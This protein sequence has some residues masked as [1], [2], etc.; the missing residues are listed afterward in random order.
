MLYH[1]A[2]P[3]RR[4]LVCDVGNGRDM[5]LMLLNIWWICQRPIVRS[6]PG[7]PAALHG[8]LHICSI[9]TGLPIAALSGCGGQSFTVLHRAVASSRVC[10]QGACSRGCCTRAHKVFALT[11]H[12]KTTR[13]YC[14]R[15][16]VDQFVKPTITGALLRCGMPNEQQACGHG[17]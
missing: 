13:Q 15:S 1:Q 7:P 17:S 16:I 5:M 9:H 2:A 3:H 6:C 12:V 4:A 11:S 8:E 10:A 14:K